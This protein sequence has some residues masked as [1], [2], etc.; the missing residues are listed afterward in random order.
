MPA[1]PGPASRGLDGP[2]QRARPPSRRPS[3]TAPYGAHLGGSSMRPIASLILALLVPY[4]VAAAA[5]EEP[6]L[7]TQNFSN[8]PRVLGGSLEQSPAGLRLRL[9]AEFS[10]PSLFKTGVDAL[11]YDRPGGA[12]GREG[13][14]RV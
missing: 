13:A 10:N 6:R 2:P 14:M 7:L 5:L 4:P 3:T 1:P 9:S 8:D 11:Y 12:A